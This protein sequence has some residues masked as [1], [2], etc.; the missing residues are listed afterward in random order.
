MGKRYGMAAGLL[1]VSVLA[2]APA[3]AAGDI[4]GVE[5]AP[6][7][8]ASGAT[9]GEPAATMGATGPGLSASAARSAAAARAA[10][11][12]PSAL[13]P[14]P[15]DLPPGARTGRPVTE[16]T[17]GA[18]QCIP[19]DRPVSDIIIANPDVADV[20]VRD[21]HNVFLIG[22]KPGSTNV[23]L[24]GRGGEVLRELEVLVVA[25]LEGAR[26]IL[27]KY[28]PHARIELEPVGS[29][30]LMTGLVRNAQ[31]AAGA[32]AVLQTYLKSAATQDQED[33]AASD[34]SFA[35]MM[36]QM[37]SEMDSGGEDG[38]GGKDDKETSASGQKT[39]DVSVI[40][41]LRI[42][43]DQQVLIKVRV[44][45]I[46][47]TT[48]KRLGV[49]FMESSTAATRDA[50]TPLQDVAT[51]ASRVGITG[52]VLG[53]WVDPAMTGAVRIGKLGLDAAT[54]S[55]LESQGLVKV[56]AE[57]ALTAI[58]GET[59]NFLA[60][61]EIPFPTRG[62]EGEI[63][64]EF[65]DVGIG[66]SFTPVVLAEDQMSLRIST[67]VSRRDPNNAIE[68]PITNTDSVTLPGLS[69]RRAQS[70]IMLPSGG[71]LMI[72]GL[73]ENSEVNEFRGVPGLMDLPV[74]GALFRSNE[75]QANRSELVVMVQAFLVRP[76]D[77]AAELALPTD[78]FVPA[79]DLD[80]YVAGRL[81]HQYGAPDD[82]T[83]NR[84]VMGA[85]LGY[86][87]E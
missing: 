77:F 10:S 75:F 66:L 58:N 8:A 85:P 53:G 57:P 23:F 6:M 73:I 1:A 62:R 60:G 16:I 48:L 80:I 61:G 36:A 47:R 56:L 17:A 14:V 2:A 38:S 55:V 27:K 19:L 9:A 43:N 24:V 69:V 79:S 37:Q 72:A 31:E 81:Y 83:A 39:E 20:V 63:M 76:I 87:M 65:K 21:P 33:G 26:R 78:G 18:T 41:A 34:G 71:S 50:F 30:V 15:L 29:G 49:N 13:T 4:D 40:N 12:A 45:E 22:H 25:D 11:A 54:F 82:P 70:T 28:L 51:G 46:G 5:L 59:A 67:E 84:L 7:A 3:L 74:L 35:S 86:I 32:Q 42:V 68:I 64:V 52:G 44:A